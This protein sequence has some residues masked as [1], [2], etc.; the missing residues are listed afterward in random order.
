MAHHRLVVGEVLSRLKRYHIRIKPSE[1]EWFKPSVVYLGHK[2]DGDGLH[3]T[4]NKADDLLNAPTPSNVSELQSYLRL[5]NF[6]GKF[7]PNLSTLLHPLHKLLCKNVP[8]VWTEACDV[9]FQQ[10]KQHLLQSQLLVHYDVNKELRPACMRQLM[11]SGQS[12]RN[13][14]ERP[15][16]FAS[17]TLSKSE[18]NYAQ[19]EREALSLIFGVKKFHKYLYGRMFTIITDHKPLTAILISKVPHT[20]ISGC[21]LL[22][23]FLLVLS[24]FSSIIVN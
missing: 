9:A 12:F 17:R 19:I 14:E 15:I 23:L 13:G 8:W 24:L 4:Q 18:K 16:A 11:G 10:S 20:H 3:P 6:Y 2:V 21:N 5:L 7:L 1:C 22:I